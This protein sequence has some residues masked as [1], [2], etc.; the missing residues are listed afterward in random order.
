MQ[1]II[2]SHYF[3][4][5]IKHNVNKNQVIQRQEKTKLGSFDIWEYAKKIIDTNVKKGN[6]KNR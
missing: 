2:F 3:S 1:W 4:D 6:I 5:W